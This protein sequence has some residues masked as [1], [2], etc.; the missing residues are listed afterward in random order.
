MVKGQDKLHNDGMPDMW[1]LFLVLLLC[2][3]GLVML[4]SS[5]ALY[6]SRATGQAWG[7]VARQ[8]AYLAA[9]FVAMWLAYRFGYERLPPVVWPALG[10]CLV[11]LVMVLVPALGT[12]AGGSQR[13]LRL[14]PIGFQPGE[15]AKVVF[16][17]YLAGSLTRK[18]EQ[19]HSFGRG[20][21]PHL[22]V[23][24]LLMA[25]L[26]AQP[27]FGSA[28]LLAMVTFFM[29]FVA[30]ARMRYLVLS[31]LVAL[32]MAY[33]LM[34]ASAYRLRRLMAFLDPWSH[35]FDIGYQVVE[36]MMGFG[37][38]GVTGTGLGAGHQK[39]FFLPAAHTDFIF[40]IVG[41]ELGFVGAFAILAIFGLVVWRGMR[42]AYLAQDL[43]GS[44]L[45]FGLS[46]MLALQVLVNI[47]VVTGLLP[48]KGLT[49]P[50]FSYGGSSLL[51]NLAAVGL[52]L[53]IS[54]RPRQLPQQPKITWP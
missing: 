37:A 13:W 28:T 8:S 33:G 2:G 48:T 47:G 15:L 9:G 36:S 35:R 26:L 43:F 50:F 51:C 21:L 18:R 7:Y 24:G 42:I 27:D 23:C 31:A 38:G 41:E 34:T 39:L 54:R 40:S 12:K 45:A 46:L 10:F 29:L 6:A 5:S 14:G 17:V 3:I 19:I 16:V 32:P 53:S 20:L 11:L 4:Y 25:L 52:L 44:Y 30:G 1:L 22:V 49:L